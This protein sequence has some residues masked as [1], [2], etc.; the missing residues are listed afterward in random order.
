[1]ADSV[2]THEVKDVLS[3]ATVNGNVLILPPGQLERGLYKKV[4]KALKNAGGKWKR[5]VGHVFT[6]DAG[7][8]LAAMLEAGV[9]VDEKKRDQAFFTPPKLAERVAEIADVRDRTVL[10]PSA[11]L[12]HL[13][14][15]CWLAGAFVVDCIERN[16]EY[17]TSL[18]SA[19]LGDV[20]LGDFLS[21]TPAD[22]DK[23]LYERIVMNPPFTKNQDIA[24]VRHALKWLAPGGILTA[25]ML[26]NQ[27]RRGFVDLNVE[28]EPEIEE[29]E[30]GAF[31]ESGT[32]ISTVIVKIQTDV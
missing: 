18:T 2:L 9:S 21:L 25:I 17:Q 26:N 12:G 6:S 5:G 32:N 8:K 24:H 22:L 31:R 1:M 10:E 30:R 15:G 7:P 3:R 29:V 20:H 28:Y 23:E 16:P 4:D 11:G 19:G 27:T 13:A 14:V